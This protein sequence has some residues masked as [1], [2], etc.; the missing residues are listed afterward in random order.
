MNFDQPEARKEAGAEQQSGQPSVMG[1]ATQAPAKDSRS[2]LTYA[3][4][5]VRDIVFIFLLWSLLAGAL[6]S[7]PLADPD[8][9]WH[10]R[11]G[12]LMLATHTLTRTD[13]FSS[14]M[15]GQKWFA[16]EWLYDLMLGAL[17]RTCGLNGVA[18]LCAVIVA[19]TFIFLLSQ[20]LR[21]GTGLPL[22]IV[23]M[24]L[25]EA[26]A[27]IHLFARPHIVSW[28]FVLLWFTALERWARGDAPRWLPWFFPVST[29]LWVN[30]HGGWLFGFALLAIYIVA[31]V[32]ESL[33]AADPFAAV[34]AWQRARGMAWAGVA[35]ALATLVNPF[36]WRLHEHIYAYLSDRYLMNRIAEFRSPDFHGWGQRC[37]V[38]ILLLTVVALAGQRRGAR[39]GP[40][41]FG[42]TRFGRLRLSHILVVLLT[43]YAG[44]LS[45]RNLPVS[46]M[47]LVLVIGPLL[48]KNLAALANRSGAW[49]WLRN[50]T[51][52][53]VEFSG[54]MEEQEMALRGHLWPAIAVVATLAICL[55]GGW[56]GSRHLIDVQFDPKKVPATAVDFLEKES[57]AEPVFS[58]DSW[59][60]YLIYRLYPSRQVVVDDRHDLYGSSRIR[61]VLILMQGE[62]GWHDVLDK[63]H[64]RTVLLPAGS[65]LP[66]LLRELPQDWRL[67]YQDDVAV[68]YEKR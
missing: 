32:V 64:I 3:V 53:M 67:T 68:V 35:S 5:S 33:R 26:A 55:H 39:S 14:T 65:T 43:V 30:L 28:L 9:G 21:R 13:S 48:W 16:W 36:G 8:I 61:E 19:T 11:N 44:L 25:A 52:R 56:L 62:P 45:S 51:R 58:T 38:V 20:L 66:S 63:W 22:A 2:L 37:F 46:S 10:I 49:P 29:V 7:R 41:R 31:A 23:L 12:E 60:G 40:G 34:K 47:L 24:L 17:D 18:W 50:G 15:H 4:P 42:H 59:G 6:S 1:V 54:R 57:N 27:S